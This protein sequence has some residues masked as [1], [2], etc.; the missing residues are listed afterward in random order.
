MLGGLMMTAGHLAEEDARGGGGDVASGGVRMNERRFQQVAR[1]LVLAGLAALGLARAEPV[2]PR[3]P[4]GSVVVWAEAGRVSVIE[5]EAWPNGNAWGRTGFHLHGASEVSFD[6][7]DSGVVPGR[8]RLG[9]L[10]RT[11]TRWTDAKGQIGNYAWTVKR[12]GAEPSAAA[13]FT[14]LGEAAFQPVR[15]SGEP[16][17]WANWYGTIQAADT[18]LLRG[19]EHIRIANRENH[20]GVLALW[21][22][23]AHALNTAKIGLRIDAPNRAFIHGMKPTIHLRVELPEGV[24]PLEAELVIEWLDLLTERR[25]VSRSAIALRGGKSEDRVLTPE[26]KPGVYRVRA[27]LAGGAASAGLENAS[28]AQVLFACSPA[29]V[30]AE[31]PDDWPLG[32]HVGP[33]LPPLPGFRWYRYFAQWPEIHVGP[34]RYEWSNFDAVFAAVRAV[35]GRLLIAS[36]GSP[37]WTSARGKAGMAWS[38]EA[39][40]YPPDDWGHLRDYL[41]AMLTRYADERG[42]LAAVELCNEA[43]TAERWL[44]DAADMLVMAR[45]FTEAVKKSGRPIQRIGLAVSA[46]DQRAF[47]SRQIEAGV[48][49]EVDAVSA[50]FYEEL[51]SPEAVT[52]INN[53]PRHVAMLREPMRAGG[54]DLPMINTECGI[55]FAPRVDDRLPTQEELNEQARGDPK[56]DVRQPWLLGS[57]WRP[58]SERRA[59]AAYVAGIVQLM[60]LDV[61][62]SYVFS[63]LELMI[64]G[65]PSLPWVALGRLGDALHG[66]DYRRIKE[67][68]AVYPESGGA[69]GEPKALAYLIGEPGGRRVI[70][71]W[72]FLSDTSTGRSKHWQRWLE[73]RALRV[74]TEVSGGWLSDLYRRNEYAVRCEAGVMEFLC[75]EEP[76]IIEIGAEDGGN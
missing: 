70:I 60:A 66:V 1:C 75:G 46:G 61:R 3:A 51:M 48:L 13:S 2:A 21:L 64:D 50:H 11:G 18:I 8:Y 14:E 57:V 33:N 16:D 72:G 6:L 37:V 49:D 31:L 26:L 32:A 7:A 42:T 71:A 4:E 63:Q 76:V 62:Q 10:A 53:L 54:F 36:D 69:D 55:G 12:K 20:G 34:G 68:K 38:A 74:E 59:A 73:P 29:R 9:L 35:G 25:V 39:T 65:A 15:E 47:V 43:N 28:S 24:A 67:L 23:P 22:Q 40:A 56:F 41:D 27:T 52:P 30:A 19:D 17:S 45:V 5:G 58:V 44:G